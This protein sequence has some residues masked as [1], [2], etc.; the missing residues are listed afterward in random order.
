M[1]TRLNKPK[2][3]LEKISETIGVII[4]VASCGVLPMNLVSKFARSKDL[5][6]FFDHLRNESE[7]IKGVFESMSDKLKLLQPHINGVS[8]MLAD[9]KSKFNVL[10]PMHKLLKKME[11]L[12][13]S[14]DRALKR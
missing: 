5:S 3:A 1:T 8:S 14:I 4:S 10:R 2:T 6:D 11:P 9:I 12:V 13:S 7:K